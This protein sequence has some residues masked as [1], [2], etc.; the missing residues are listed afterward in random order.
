MMAK[1]PTDASI[2][3]GGAKRVAVLQSNYLPWKGYFDMIASV[4]QFVILDTVQFTK[5]DWRNRNRI[6]T[7]EIGNGPKSTA[8]LTVPVLTA[9]RFGQPIRDVIIDSTTPWVHRHCTRIQQEYARAAYATT[10]LPWITE[11]IGS[12]GEHRSLSSVNVSLIR[13]VCARLGITTDL[14]DAGDLPDADDPNDRLVAI[15]RALGASRYI[16]GPAAASY[17]DTQRFGDHGIEVEWFDYAGYEP[18]RQTAEPFIAEVSVIDTLLNTGPEARRMVVRADRG[19][20]N[21][22]QQE[23]A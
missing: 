19:P 17:L 21:A 9:G 15:C 22:D 2:P 4:D 7:R 23:T 20:G 12:A 3:G 11:A 5:N 1:P 13:D 8:W 18:Y 16:S 6:R 14:V 10:E